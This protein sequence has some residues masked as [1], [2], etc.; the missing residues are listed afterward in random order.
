MSLS[1]KL[2]EN[3]I[4]NELTQNVESYKDLN[5]DKLTELSNQAFLIQATQNDS[6]SVKKSLQ[7][8][9]EHF[10]SIMEDS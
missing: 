2:V 1:R 5:I 8:K 9:I 6:K 10:N 3:L 7:D 4:K